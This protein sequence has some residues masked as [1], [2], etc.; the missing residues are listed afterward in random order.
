MFLAWSALTSLTSQV[1][2]AKII[3]FLDVPRHD[4]RAWPSLTDPAW[5]KQ[6]RSLEITKKVAYA[7]CFQYFL[8]A[9]RPKML[10]ISCVFS[11]TSLDQWRLNMFW[12]QATKRCADFRSFWCMFFLFNEILNLSAFFGLTRLDQAK[13]PLLLFVI[14]RFQSF[15]HQIPNF[16]IQFGRQFCRP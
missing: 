3:L 5:S 7:N 13:F 10:Q 6:R 9:Y 14:G 15:Y 11:L 1:G 4:Q 12:K 2:Q 8:C 16:A